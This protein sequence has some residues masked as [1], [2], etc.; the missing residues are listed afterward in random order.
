MQKSEKDN[1]NIQSASL[2]DLKAELFRKQ[3]EFKA[4][5]LQNQSSGF[6][7]GKVSAGNKKPSL[8]NKKNAG[9]SQRAEK[10]Y[11]EKVEEENVFERSRKALENKAKLYDEIASGST[12]PD[13][14]GSGQF[15]VDFQKKVL[16]NCV[17]E[18][19]SDRREF[20]SLEV[21]RREK[22]RLEIEEERKQ[23][24]EPVPPP[25]SVDDEW[26]DYVDAF[27]RSRSC[28]RKDLPDLLKQDE[29]LQQ[30]KRNMDEKSEK[31][32]K[33]FLQLRDK[34]SVDTPSLLSNDMR[35]E[36][37]REQ[38]EKEEIDKLEEEKS[39]PIHYT[40]VQHN[41]IRRHGVGY[42]KFDKEENTRQEQMEQLNQLRQQTKDERTK[43]EKIKE[44]RKAALQAR[45][46]KVKQRKRERLGL[47]E[48][49][50][51]VNDEVEPTSSDTVVIK[52]E[53][54]VRD[55]SW[56]SEIKST[57][58]WDKGKQFSTEYSEKAWLEKQRAERDEE[59]APPSFYYD[60][61]PKKNPSDERDKKRNTS[62]KAERPEDVKSI[63]EKQLSDIRQ[64]ETDVFDDIDKNVSAHKK[65]KIEES[66]TSTKDVTSVTYSTNTLAVNLKILPPSSQNSSYNVGDKLICDL[67][68]NMSF[69]P[70][71][72]SIPPP[73]LNMNTNF[74]VPSPIPPPVH[75]SFPVNYDIPPPQ[76]FAP[77]H[78]YNV[79][80]PNLNIPP[81]NLNIPPPNYIAPPTT[82]INPPVEELNY[83]TV[84][85]ELNTPSV[86]QTETIKKQFV[87]K[88]DIIDRRLMENCD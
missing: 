10:D 29:S 40:D 63:I 54:L 39:G 83:P 43:V 13:E 24:L 9:V 21:E 8:F 44:K 52:P 81:P 67:P 36:M 60:N 55:D 41:E 72:V 4:Q 38:W 7:K 49:E 20:E 73:T 57:R 28:L 75:A 58:D 11:T 66:P 87:A 18:R 15:L 74:T 80:P 26:V 30:K 12:I 33:D 84:G 23:L 77:P 35:R 65:I 53:P 14:D 31:G 50:E 22:E 2:I 34:T 70:A 17:D 45:L 76:S 86:S 69:I 37:V 19:E 62:I 51:D 42:Y 48:P 79:P 3:E 82:T 68:S 61:V 25:D 47:P 5:K 32:Y 88:E 46:A 16:D 64:S 1:T 78:S 6:V 56:R 27:G 59:F 85:L 71:D